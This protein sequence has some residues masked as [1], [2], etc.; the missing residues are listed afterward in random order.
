VNA[1][2]AE[3]DSPNQRAASRLAG[4]CGG[5]IL[6][7][8][9][10]CECALASTEVEITPAP[11]N[12]YDLISLQKGA[13]HFANYCLSCHSANYMRYNRLT[14]LGLTEDQIRQNL[15]A[16]GEKVGEPMAIALK[17]ADGKRWFGVAPPDLSVIARSRGADW[18]Y[19]YLRGFYRDDSRPTGWNNTVFAQVGMPHVLYRLQGEQ[20]LHVPEKKGEGG[21]GEEHATLVLDKPGTLKPAQYDEFVADLVNYLVYMGEPA[22]NTRI[23]TGILVMFFLAVLFVLAFA[24]KK[25]YWKDV[26]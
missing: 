8:L 12:S 3:H 6:L 9:V 1:P 5:I 18:L 11:I 10:V 2:L 20:V 15:I 22:R 4:S 16:T 13:R 19:S 23:L 14:D 25:E 24:L 7:L 26:H 21:H 17:P